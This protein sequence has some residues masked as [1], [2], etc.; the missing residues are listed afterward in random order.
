[1]QPALGD[2]EGALRQAGKLVLPRELHAR[3]VGDARV[4]RAEGG[5]DLVAQVCMVMLLS[6]SVLFIDALPVE[7]HALLRRVGL[8]VVTAVSAAT[9]FMLKARTAEMYS[10]YQ[11]PELRD[12]A[13]FI[14][15]SSYHRCCNF[16]F[17]Q[18]SK[19]LYKVHSMWSNPGHAVFLAT[20]PKRDELYARL[21][22]MP[23]DRADGA[24]T[25]LP[26]RLGA[27]IVMEPAAES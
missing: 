27:S 11:P 9:Y 20:A 14:T 19:T 8:P 21:Y 26:P 13:G 6:L 5:V 23:S 22:G 4:A 3:V 25:E 12:V 24:A 15:L 16:L 1:M 10:K 17:F 18:A 7:M 2:E